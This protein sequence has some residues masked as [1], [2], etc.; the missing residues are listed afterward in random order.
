MPRRSLFVLRTLYVFAKLEEA[1]RETADELLLI[2]PG[3]K[4]QIAIVRQL[5]KGIEDV[6]LIRHGVSGSRELR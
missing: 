6:H 5:V 4:D 2:V 1:V 3:T